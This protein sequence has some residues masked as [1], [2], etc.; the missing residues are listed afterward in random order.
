MGRRERRRG[1]GDDEDVLMRLQ[2]TR[3]KAIV[4]A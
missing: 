1:G 3:G 4:S 2:G